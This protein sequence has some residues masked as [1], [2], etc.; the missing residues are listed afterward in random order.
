MVQEFWGYFFQM[1][2]CYTFVLSV[3]ICCITDVFLYYFLWRSHWYSLD[4]MSARSY[5]SQLQGF[6]FCPM[7]SL[8]FGLLNQGPFSELF[9]YLFHFIRV[10]FTTEVP[11]K[12]AIVEVGKYEWFHQYCLLRHPHKWR[13][14]SGQLFGLLPSYIS[15]LYDH[16]M[17]GDYW[18]QCLVV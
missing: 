15:C 9:L 1:L 18:Y 11:D 8:H 17:I 5:M 12:W 4:L 2:Q 10:S 3:Y 7:Q 16:E 6:L 14:F 13:V